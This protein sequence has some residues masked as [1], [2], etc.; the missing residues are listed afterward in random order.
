MLYANG[1]GYSDVDTNYHACKGNTYVIPILQLFLNY[2][3]NGLKLLIYRDSTLKRP[4][5]LR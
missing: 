5:N 3:N 1:V 4:K 2:I